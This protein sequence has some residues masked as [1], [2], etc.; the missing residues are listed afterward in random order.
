MAFTPDDRFVISSDRYG[1]IEVRDAA[2]GRVVTSF[3]GHKQTNGMAL[4]RDG[5]TL[6]TVGEGEGEGVKIWRAAKGQ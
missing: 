1:E 5:S 3:R 2:T 6:V 4:S